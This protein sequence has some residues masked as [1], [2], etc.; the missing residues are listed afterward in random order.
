VKKNFFSM[1][2]AFDFSFYFIKK[3]ISFI[4]LLFTFY[5][6]YNTLDTIRARIRLETLKSIIVPTI[7]FPYR[8]NI[9]SIKIFHSL[10]LSSV[11]LTV[12]YIFI[13]FFD[14]L[15]TL[16]IIKSAI[17]WKD[18]N[19]INIKESLKNIFSFRII[20]R[21]INGYILLIA[22]IFAVEIASF[23]VMF[24]PFVLMPA[25][26]MLTIPSFS[27]IIGNSF[28]I[29]SVSLMFVSLIISICF[30]FRYIFFQYIIIDKNLTAKE[31][32]KLS[33]T[34][35]E[36]KRWSLFGLWIVLFIIC[37]LPSIM[38]EQILRHIKI[39]S[40]PLF[41]IKLSIFSIFRVFILVI[42]NFSIFHVYRQI[43]EKNEVNK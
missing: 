32:F 35:T 34:I 21:I 25:L 33:E 8:L 16:Y 18:N 10:H 6:I 29:S 17:N 3:N 27:K 11:I 19:S 42:Y 9:Y 36:N 12:L 13:L 31:S 37:Y 26:F 7:L 39:S 30:V 14:I 28:A 4:G 38:V 2:E 43:I 22:R 40:V 5:L 41:Y 24:V 15:V 20:F 23:L 1:K